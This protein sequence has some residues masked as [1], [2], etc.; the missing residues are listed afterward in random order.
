[1]S[2]LGTLTARRVFE[3]RS[4]IGAA[5]RWAGAEPAI[6]ALALVGSQA[7]GD[8][9]MLSDVD[10][11]VLAVH[12]ASLLHGWDVWSFLGNPVAVRQH[13]W[14]GLVETRLQLGTG[15]DVDIDVAS[16]RWARAPLEDGARLLLLGGI[17]VLHDPDGLLRAAL[18]AL[19]R[20]FAT[21]TARPA[22]ARSAL[23][24][25]EGQPPHEVL[26]EEEGQQDPWGDGDQRQ[27]GDLAPGD[28]VPSGHPGEGDG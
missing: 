13:W 26:L 7:R 5:T 3:I 10:L 28:L 27:G 25:A 19:P 11:L 20:G 1:M 6:R 2:L 12:P 18:E 23:H 17:R 9:D 16:T 24:R 14:G 8:P 4:V 15:L 22:P 21:G